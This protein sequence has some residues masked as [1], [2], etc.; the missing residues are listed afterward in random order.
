MNR[1]TAITQ[2]LFASGM[3]LSATTTQALQRYTHH[4]QPYSSD[5]TLSLSEK[6][7]L[8]EIVDL[9]LP[10]TNTPSASEAQVHDFVEMMLKDCYTSQ[11]QE[12]F[13][14]GLQELSK[15]LQALNFSEKTPFLLKFEAQNN[16]QNRTQPQAPNCWKIL[17]EMTLV[18]YFTSEIG[19]TQAME[20]VPVPSKLETIK[21]TKGQRAFSEYLGR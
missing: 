9:I 11:A 10:K 5:F 8:K 2:L 18:G 14:K 7:A 3:V 20:Y 12:V 16:E 21:I 15:E 17:K 19:M 13:V 4:N 1:R 6:N